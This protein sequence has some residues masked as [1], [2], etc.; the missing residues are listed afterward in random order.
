MIYI[1]FFK[2]IEPDL[3]ASFICIKTVS[4]VFFKAEF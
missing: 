3:H 2:K 4:T 1:T